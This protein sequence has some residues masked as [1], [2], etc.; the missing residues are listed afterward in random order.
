MSDY[1]PQ[2]LMIDIFTKLPV[3]SI[4]RFTSACKS[5]TQHYM[6]GSSHWIASKCGDGPTRSMIVLFDMHDE[7]FSE[8]MLPSNLSS[9]LRNCDDVF[10]SV[11]EESLCLVNI[12][13]IKSEPIDIWIMREYGAPESWVK[14]FSIS[15]RNFTRNI[16]PD[17]LEVTHDLVKP[18]AI[19]KNGEIIWK[20]KRANSR[21]L[22][23]VDHVVGKFKDIGIGNSTNDWCHNPLYVN[24]YK[25]SLVLLDK[26]TNNCVGDACEESSD[27]WKRAQRW[28]KKALKDKNYK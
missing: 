20:A 4:L 21:L 14:Q 6:N 8:M 11:L 15:S 19:R 5:C 22:V 24:Y 7:K 2:E 1:L 26:W 12:D 9:K 13:Y 17:E 10:L 16:S 28:E 18:M 25:E 27:L 3:K 23:S